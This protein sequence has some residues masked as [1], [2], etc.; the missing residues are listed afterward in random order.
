M[1][2]PVALQL[3]SVRDFASKDLA[4]VLKQVKEMG[5]DG[6]EFAGFYD[7][8]AADVKAMLDDTGLKVAG[9]H[10]GLP[11]LMD[12]AFEKTVDFNEAIGS[13]YPV[14][15]SL[16]E[17]YR[18]DADSLKRF[19]DILNGLG[20]KLA[21]RGMKTGYHNHWWE[22]DA[23]D[24]QVPWEV[25][26]DNTGDALIHQFDTGNGLRGG[27]IAADYIRKYPGR[28]TTVHLKEWTADN[29]SAIL[30]EGDV[31]FADVFAACNE[32]GGTEWYIV[33]QEKYDTDSMDVARRNREAL[34]GMGV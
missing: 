21:A 30:G 5:Y 12:D 10:T 23:I 6:V 25:I 28:S 7:H 26:F 4:G 29:E 18:Q 16:S 8:S 1:A 13:K 19:A 15:P 17:E 33:E 32:V 22:Y 11:L 24:G 31:P 14:V 3:Y 34:R 27:G 2:I 20:D 9:S